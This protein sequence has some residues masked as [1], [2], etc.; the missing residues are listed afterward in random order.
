VT[1]ST[2]NGGQ[3][4]M[5]IRGPG[6][7]P[8]QDARVHT[9]YHGDNATVA[10]PLGSKAGTN[11]RI[12]DVIAKDP[13]TVFVLPESA[14]AGEDVDSPQHDNHYSVHWENTVRDQAQTTDDA[15]AGAGITK[16]GKQIVSFHSGGGKVVQK[17]MELDPSGARLR[18]DRLELHDCFYGTKGHDWKRGPDAAGWEQSFVRW[19]H[20]PNGQHVTDVIY[21]HGSNEAPRQNVVAKAFEGKYTKVEM[22]EQ[23]AVEDHNPVARDSDRNTF[24]T[25]DVQWVHGKRQIVHTEVHNYNPDPHYRTTGQFLGA[26][27]G[28]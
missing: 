18:A 26:A 24:G 16:I 6:F 21:Y 20:T 17:L 15:L 2:G 25:I 14:A 1:T 12:R 7:D 4:V 5:V 11:A 19:A 10:D 9:H 23:G 22:S 8:T 3:P 27:P 28:P 13:Q